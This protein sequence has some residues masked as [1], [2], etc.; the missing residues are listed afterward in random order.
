MVD[1]SPA[2]V[3]AAEPRQPGWQQQPSGCASSVCTAARHVN[4]GK[5]AAP[6]KRCCLAEGLDQRVLRRQDTWQPATAHAEVTCMQVRVLGCWSSQL[7][8]EAVQ[9]ADCCPLYP[10]RPACERCPA[11]PATPSHRL[12]TSTA[13]DPCAVYV[14]AGMRCS[15]TDT[16]HSKPS[17]QNK[18][19]P[20]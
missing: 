17:S 2:G 10:A 20:A 1:A 4:E 9:H 5:G 11:V 16:Y 12:E 8:V 14:P 18:T 15:A 13:V 3:R 6:A 7:E 19:H